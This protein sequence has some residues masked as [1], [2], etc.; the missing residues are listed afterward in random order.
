MSKE[1]EDIRDRLNYLEERLD[2]FEDQVESGL[3]IELITDIFR[4]T[5]GKYITPK[6]NILKERIKKLE[7]KL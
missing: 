3:H 6:I 7:E 1:L 5:M 2:A 4:S